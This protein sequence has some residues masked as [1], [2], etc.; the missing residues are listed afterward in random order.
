MLV[1]STINNA[2]GVGPLGGD[3]TEFLWASA[4]LF[5]GG[6]IAGGLSVGDSDGQQPGVT[7]KTCT[8]VQ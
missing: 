2:G 8:M 6:G 4:P 7:N 1:Y 3:P 5:L